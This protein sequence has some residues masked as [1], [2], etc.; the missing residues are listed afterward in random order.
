MKC[1]FGKT[2]QIIS[3]AKLGYSGISCKETN[4]KITKVFFRENRTFA[5]IYFINQDAFSTV[6]KIWYRIML[7]RIT[8][9]WKKVILR[10]LYIHYMYYVLYVICIMYYIY[11]MAKGIWTAWLVS[12]PGKSIAS[13]LD[14]CPKA[15][16]LPPY[17]FCP[18]SCVLALHKMVETYRKIIFLK[19]LRCNKFWF[20]LVVN[21]LFRLS[22]GYIL[23]I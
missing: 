4:M 23:E 14:L 6:T 18:F 5:K 16:S 20:L 11:G 12:P 7:V 19:F 22:T 1:C 15:W 21:S 2:Y 17:I 3:N 13:F 8:L 9:N 10:Q